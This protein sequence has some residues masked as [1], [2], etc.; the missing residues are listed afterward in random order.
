MPE[1]A[2]ASAGTLTEAVSLA[3][4]QFQPQAMDDSLAYGS[5]SATDMKLSTLTSE[6]NISV[7]VLST[8][9]AC[10]PLLGDCVQSCL[11]VQ[12][13]M[14][15]HLT[16]L[17]HQEYVSGFLLTLLDYFLHVLLLVIAMGQFCFLLKP[18]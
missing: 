17:S 9:G 5:Q 13:Q 6:K 1:L 14:V 2:A 15:F 10:W 18:V 11:L 7:D 16:E 8:A 4:W 12:Q 3:A